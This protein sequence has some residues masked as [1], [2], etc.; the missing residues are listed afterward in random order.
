MPWDG[1][2][3]LRSSPSAEEVGPEQRGT[4]GNLSG[5]LWKRLLGPPVDS[6]YEFAQLGAVQNANLLLLYGYRK[7]AEKEGGGTLGFLL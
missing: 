4:L 6:N 5:G 3:H 2:E 7:C 1:A